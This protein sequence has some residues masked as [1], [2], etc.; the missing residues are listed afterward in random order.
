MCYFKSVFVLF[1]QV[2]TDYNS[3]MFL[4]K[5][6]QIFLAGFR[7]LLRYILV[8]LDVGKTDFL[9]PMHHHAA[10]GRHSYNLDG[11]MLSR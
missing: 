9:D 11:W 7:A 5:R 4:R 3:F 6:I 8:A 1:L 2:F 10:T